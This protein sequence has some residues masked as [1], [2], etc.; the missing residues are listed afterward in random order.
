M[1]SNSKQ[2]ENFS[3]SISEMGSRPAATYLESA[4]APLELVYT[5]FRQY[6]KDSHKEITSIAK[7]VSELQ[8]QL[9]SDKME[10]S[11][12]HSQ[13]MA[14]LVALKARID[15]LRES[16]V[17]AFE[18][19]SSRLS[20]C[21]TRLERSH[22]LQVG[23]SNTT[24][25]LNMQSTR[26]AKEYSARAMAQNKDRRQPKS[27]RSKDGKSKGPESGWQENLQKAPRVGPGYV[28]LGKTAHNHANEKLITA[29]AS[30]SENPFSNYGSLDRRVSYQILLD[31]R[32]LGLSYGWP[33][34]Q[35]TC[36][37]LDT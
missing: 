17:A 21:K 13:F 2:D 34:Q 19:D 22:Y 11:D 37:A 31:S 1:L 28:P 25:S 26:W 10:P 36:Y 5:K 3:T 18:S 30:V 32:A 9:K 23:H 4:R 20:M 12:K 33:S 15:F 16:E 35:I 8:S 14:E 29:A 7:R 27:T 24:S 6:Q